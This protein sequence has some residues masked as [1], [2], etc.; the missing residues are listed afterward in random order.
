MSR[1]RYAVWAPHATRVELVFTDHEPGAVHDAADRWA[2]AAVAPMVPAGAGWW[3][4]EAPVE[5]RYA[6]AGYG[7]RVDGEGP[8]PDPRSRSQPD[9]VHGPSRRVDADGFAWRDGDWSGRDLRGAVLYELHVGTFTDEGTL[10][11]AAGKLEHLV[12]LGVTHVELLPVNSFAGGHNW[13]YD[14]VGW[15]AVDAS[16]GGPVAYRRF[17]DDCH[18]AGLAVV[19]DVV[20]NHLGPSG[21]YLPRFGPYLTERSTG[22]GSGLNLD[23][24]DSDEV[25]RYILDN[26]RMWFEEYHVDGLRLDAVHAL[27]DTRA[28]HVLE[29]LAAETDALSAALGRPLVLVA[30]SD[31]NDPR[32]ISPRAAPGRDGAGGYGLTGQWS[33]DFHHAVHVALTGETDGYYADFGPLSALSK[34]LNH[35]FFHDGSYSSFRGRH[36]GRPLGDQVPAEALV[37]FAQNHDQVGNR[38][39]GD[40]L[41]ATLDEGQ[42]AIA[43]ALLLAGPFTPMLFMGEEWA[44]STPWQ[45]FTAHREPDLARAV[46]EGRRREFERMAWG[47]DVPDPQAVQ[48]LTD[49]TLRW[50]EAA[51]GRH[52]RLLE[53]HRNLIRVRAERP[54]LTDPDRAT[55]RATVNEERQ[56]VRMDRG[57][58]GDGPGVVVLLAALGSEPWPVPEDVGG[59]RLLAVHG[60]D[61]PL[62]GVPADGSVPSHGFVLLSRG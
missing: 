11:A 27:Q 22:W 53:L 17:V 14:G 16:Y 47:Q 61:G 13:G 62:T 57:V 30:E 28:V 38:A 25:R 8:F 2:V 4:P 37:V 60:P 21:N 5:E 51:T 41:T 35:G 49:S 43:A 29:E 9:T 42:L 46:T 10:A 7:Y 59:Y 58:T 32:L 1:D 3:E 18:A 50:D 26:A 15:Y 55:T 48:T 20:Y 31:L 44:A 19:Q 36:H 45:F 34:V 40:R 12:S 23:G 52:A 56:W 33:D 54:E 24:E 6:A 39:T